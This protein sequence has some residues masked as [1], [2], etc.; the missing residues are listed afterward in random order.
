MGNQLARLYQELEKNIVLGKK[1]FIWKN[2][3]EIGYNY[4]FNKNSNV[5]SP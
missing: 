5:E 1:I 3:L 2:F 4:G